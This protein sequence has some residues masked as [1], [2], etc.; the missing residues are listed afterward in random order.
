VQVTAWCG[1]CGESF[2]LD[3]MTAQGFSGRCPRC[4]E[5]LS[6]DYTP[7]ASAAVHEL[8]DAAEQLSA[9]AIRLREVAPRLHLDARRLTADISESLDGQ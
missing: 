3:E 9:A 1:W 4:G 6:P 2:R 7:V 8:L 5:P